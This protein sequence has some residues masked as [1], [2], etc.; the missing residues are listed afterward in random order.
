MK[1]IWITQAIYQEDYK[2]LLH[3][4]NG[5]EGL[6][7]LENKLQ[8]PI[9]EPLKDLDFFKRF[10]LNDWTLEWPNGA[11]LAPEYLYEQVLENQT[12]A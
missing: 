6:V 5:V 7:N 11:D 8:G 3:F 4:S 9:F 10:I 2:I 1:A 12:I